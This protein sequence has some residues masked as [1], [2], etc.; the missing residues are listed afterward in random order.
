M[1]EPQFRRMTEEEFLDWHERQEYRYE[2]VSGFPI[3]IFPPKGMTGGTRNHNKVAHNVAYALTPTARAKGCTPVT[4][5]AAIRA[6]RGNLRYPDVTVDCG[7]QD[8]KDRVVDIPIVVAEVRSPTNTSA[9]ITDK[10]EEY[11]G[12]GAIRVIMLVEPEIVSVKL[13]RRTDD[14]WA[15]ERYYRLDR[16]IPLPEI[17]GELPMAD[18]YYG[19]DP[20]VGPD[21]AIVD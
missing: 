17:G 18:I 4:H 9:E 8:G 12:H 1:A 10:L 6:P 15:I 16:T 13:Y 19:L 2:L 14:G 21:L 20:E 3:Q 7:E 11:Q 5:N